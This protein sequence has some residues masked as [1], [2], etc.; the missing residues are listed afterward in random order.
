MALE[1]MLGLILFN[2]FP[3]F[4]YLFSFFP[5]VMSG[6]FFIAMS[7]PCVMLVNVFYLQFEAW[8]T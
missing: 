8:R 3:A 4:V 6:N 2:D 5:C 1:L 7:F